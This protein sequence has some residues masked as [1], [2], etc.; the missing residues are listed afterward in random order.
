MLDTDSALISN[1]KL[2]ERYEFAREH[3]RHE[4]GLVNHRVT[5]FLV[6]QGL[7]FTALMAGFGLLDLAKEFDIYESTF[8]RVVLDLLLLLG[9]G[10]SLVAHR[11]IRAAYW[12]MDEVALWWAKQTEPMPAEVKPEDYFPPVRGTGVSPA[13][14]DSGKIT[15]AAMLLI[16]GALWFVL[17]LCFIALQVRTFISC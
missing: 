1:P 8:I 12:Q 5:W 15:A 10:S 7:L 14:T 9:I 3:L 17:L 16:L 2:T 4:D 6:F 13:I 11:L